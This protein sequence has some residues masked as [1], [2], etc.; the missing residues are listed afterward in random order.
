MRCLPTS[1]QLR[2]KFT[3]PLIKSPRQPAVW[4]VMIRICKIFPPVD[5]VWLFA[6]HSNL[7][8]DVSFWPLI[9]P[10]LNCEYWRIFQVMK[11]LLQ[12][13][14]RGLIFMPKQRHAFLKCP[15]LLLPASN[16]SWANESIL[17]FCMA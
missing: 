8:R 6:K 14:C 17:V 3:L 9:I 12:A 15:L 11:I 1:I 13:L 16:G 10:K 7:I 2:T 5:M 4:P